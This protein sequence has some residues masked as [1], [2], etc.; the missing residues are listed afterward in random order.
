M[1]NT[2]STVVLVNTVSTAIL[3]NKQKPKINLS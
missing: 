2:V 3:T 1:V